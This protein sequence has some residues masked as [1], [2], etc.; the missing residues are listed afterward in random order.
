MIF[1]SVMLCFGLTSAAIC[2]AQ[3]KGKDTDTKLTALMVAVDSARPKK[4]VWPLA[5]KT[6]TSRKSEGLFTLYQDTITGNVQLYIRKDQLGKEFIYQSF[7]LNGPTSLYLNQSMHRANFIF[8]VQ[9]AFDKLEFSRVNTSFYYDPTNAISRTKDVD[10][11]EAVMS[12]ERISGEDSTG[13]LINADGLFMTERLDPVKPISPPSFFSIPTFNL[14][15]LNPM[16]SK[17]AAV[18]SFPNNSDIIVDLAYDNANAFVTSGPDITDARY[19]RVRMQHSFVA[20]PDND[21]KPRRDDP[22]IGF[23]GHEVTDQTSMSATPYRDII[24]RWNLRKKDPGDALSEPVEPIVYWI[25]NTTPVEYRETVMEA[26]L[27][28]NKAF[29][30]AGFKNAVQI[31]IMPDDADWDPA[32]LR[33][34]VIRWVSSANPPY[35]AIGPRM[36]NPKTG[37]ILGADITIEWNFASGAPVYDELFNGKKADALHFPGMPHHDYSNCTLGTELVSNFMLGS[38]ALDVNHAGPKEIKE[39][40]RQFL[41]WAIMHEMGHTLGLTHNMKASQMLSLADINNTN[42]TRKQGLV[43]SVMDYTIINV[44]P[45]PK[46]QGDYYTTLAGP[47]DEWAIEYGYTPFEEGKEEAGLKS[48]LSRSTD[49]KLA[50]GNDGDDMRSPGKG[51]DP[52]VNVWD[53]SNDAIGYAEQRFQVVNNLM[54]KLLQKYSKEG[55]SYAELRSRYNA[56]QSQRLNMISAISRYIG[57]VYV[58]RSFPEQLSANK[59]FTPVT[60]AEQKRAINVL[61]KYVFA[62]GA[63]SNDAALYAYLQPQRRLFNQSGIGDDYKITAMVLNNQLGGALAHIMH[64]ATLQRITNSSL[65]GNAYSV[66]DMM[67]DLTT[68]ILAADLKTAVTLQRQYLQTSF[69]KGLLSMIDPRMPQYDDIAKAAA[70]HTVR[71]IKAQMQTAVS[72]NEETKA[73]RANLVYMITNSLDNK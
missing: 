50:F 3:Q 24:Q 14:G 38:T 67:N 27:K 52:R 49:P 39:L 31:K 73:H 63:Y 28:W 64:P 53:L 32:D 65:Y 58:D 56:L 72:P 33:Y 13:F 40:H 16:K 66:A 22:R 71:K 4:P 70:L 62:P 42:I 41:T 43:G 29:E 15:G 48:I 45:D 8:K 44:S 35:G 18:R 5:E 30:K 36:V 2:H 55:Q 59:P 11:P 20:M 21:F 9:K 6:K 19:V 25:E 68:G 57:G 37:Q 34:N 61:N 7:S 23:F 47:Y 51:M 26:G 60:A 46:K 54:G 1:R 17:Y 10:K 69:V 12:V